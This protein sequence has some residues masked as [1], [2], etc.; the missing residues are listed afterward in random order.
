MSRSQ[1]NPSY[2]RNL[3]RYAD[4]LTS[5]FW[6]LTS[7]FRPSDSCFPP[8]EAG[9]LMMRKDLENYVGRSG[10]ENPRFEINSGLLGRSDPCL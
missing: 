1:V 4:I 7:V 9:M 10:P 5:D 2:G 6:L 3:G 8:S